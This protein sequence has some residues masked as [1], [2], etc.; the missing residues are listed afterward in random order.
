MIR[1][2]I[3]NIIYLSGC[4]LKGEKADIDRI[5][6]MDLEALYNASKRQSMAAIVGKALQDAGVQN[7][8]FE[9]ALAKSV[10]KNVLLKRELKTITDSFE[11]NHIWYLP[12]KGCIMMDYYPSIGVREMSDIDILVDSSCAKLIK[13]IM[14][15]LGFETVSFNLG[16][17]DLYHKKPVYNIEIHRSLVPERKD[18]SV[19]E[20]YY[21][22]P[23]VILKTT[24]SEY[25]K[26]LSKEDFYI[27]MIAHAYKHYIGGGTGLRSLMDIYVYLSKFEKSMDMSYVSN[28]LKKL[29][30]SNFEET[31]KNLSFDLYNRNRLSDDEKEMLKYI[32]SSGAYGSNEHRYRNRLKRNE[33]SKLSYVLKRVFVTDETVKNYYPFFY[34]FPIFLPALWIYR[35]LRTIFVR[36]KKIKKELD[37]L[38]REKKNND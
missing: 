26:E 4:V 1:E 23:S 38:L 24:D 34:K 17:H 10:R 28:E 27:F 3:D 19:I 29:E 6:K 20:E 5:S 16:A 8:A 18:I 37:F 2:E 32:Y 7:E 15:D 13:T 14:T 22:N 31:I 11:K 21:K 12:L 33:G 30:I 25:R 9:Q 35:I 36:R